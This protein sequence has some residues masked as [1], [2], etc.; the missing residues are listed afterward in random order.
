MPSN[1]C[2]PS[3]QPSPVPPVPITIFQRL[4]QSHQ[5]QFAY[6]VASLI[7]RVHATRQSK[8]GKHEH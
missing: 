4:P 3:T 5:Q 2:Q 7:R 8:E 1:P 6:L